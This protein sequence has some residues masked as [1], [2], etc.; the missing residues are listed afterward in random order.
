M[1][2]I[3]NICRMQDINWNQ[4]ERKD[5]CWISSGLYL[6]QHLGFPQWPARCLWEDH[7]EGIKA[8]AI[9]TLMWLM[10]TDPL[11][12]LDLMYTIVVY[13][14]SRTLLQKN[15]LCTNWMSRNRLLGVIPGYLWASW[16][17]SQG[18]HFIFMNWSCKCPFHT[19][20]SFMKLQKNTKSLAIV[21]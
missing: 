11:S 6:V 7:K 3:C 10:V 13:G 1:C 2:I 15:C 9:G 5:P 20:S 21:Y 12:G 14:T 17:L 18:I 8:M 4:R 19:M 16:T